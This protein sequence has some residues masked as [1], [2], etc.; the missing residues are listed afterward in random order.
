MFGYGYKTNEQLVK[1]LKGTY[2]TSK[3]VERAMGSVDRA[4]FSE[5]NP[6]EDAPQSIGYGVTISA[7]H[8]HAT[9][10]EQLKDYLKEGM[11]ALDIGSGTGYLTACMARMVGPS[12]R[13]YGVEYIKPVYEE[14]IENLNKDPFHR[15]LLKKKQIEIKCDDGWK[16]WEEKGPFNAIHVGAAADHIPQN[17][18]DQLASPGRLVIP[19]G[20]DGGFQEFLKIDKDKNGNLKEPVSI[21]SVRYVPLVNPNRIK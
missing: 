7:P 4:H 3:E 18:I 8:M 5:Y 12:G 20:P 2:F 10:L 15:E 11:V 9:A 17:L 1:H 6:Y 21:F 13:A 16:G 19:V 14:S